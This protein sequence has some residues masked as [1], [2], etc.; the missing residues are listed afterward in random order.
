M[1]STPM[2]PT[3]MAPTPTAP[4]PTVETP[5]VRRALPMEV[6]LVPTRQVARL[7]GWMV[8]LRAWEAPRARPAVRTFG[9]TRQDR[10]ALVAQGSAAVAARKRLGWHRYWQGLES[11]ARIHCRCWGRL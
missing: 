3:P 4:T 6:T 5:K 11:A 10:T 1:A 2:A 8:R 7:R 9:C